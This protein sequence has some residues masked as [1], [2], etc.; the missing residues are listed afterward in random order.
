MPTNEKFNHYT[1][2]ECRTGVNQLVE[3]TCHPADKEKVVAFFKENVRQV[4]HPANKLHNVT[5]GGYGRYT[6]FDIKQHKYAGGGSGYIEAIEIKDAPEGHHPF[7]IHEYNSGRSKFWEIKTV[8]RLKEIWE[9][10]WGSNDRDVKTEGVIRFVD[11]S[12]VSPWFYAMGDQIIFRDFVIPDEGLASHPLYQQGKKFLLTCSFEKPQIKTC[13]CAFKIEGKE[14]PYYRDRKS[15]DYHVVVFTDGSHY[16]ESHR[17]HN[18][19]LLHDDELWIDAA[20]EQFHKLLTG[21]KKN[22]EIP[23]IDGSSFVGKFKPSRL[24]DTA[25]TYHIVARCK[26]NGKP[27]KTE[28]AVEFEPTKEVPFVKDFVAAQAKAKGVELVDM[29]S[30]LREAKD[31]WTGVFTK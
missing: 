17:S 15:S 22:F 11:C 14:D 9:R 16:D 2:V 5:H 18:L 4:H 28:G 6:R 21:E 23:F 27:L 8:E 10:W 3:V 24:R 19:R 20:I 26:K 29:E 13:L 25:G 30:V 7:L 1:Y 12:Y 31:G